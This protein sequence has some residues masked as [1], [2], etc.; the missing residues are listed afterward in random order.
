MQ[1]EINSK[2]SLNVIPC[3]FKCFLI[4]IYVNKET[5]QP[6]LN[7]CLHASSPS[8]LIRSSALLQSFVLLPLPP[9]LLTFNPY[10]PNVENRVSS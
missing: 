8:L 9:F 6:F 10:P 1:Y 3:N 7:H 5:N 4:D 2:L